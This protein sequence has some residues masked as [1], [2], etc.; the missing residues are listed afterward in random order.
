MGNSSG[1][2]F[3][4]RRTRTMP[5]NAYSDYPDDAK[6]VTMRNTREYR[7][8]SGNA[9]PKPWNLER[10]MEK[11]PEMEVYRGQQCPM[12]FHQLKEAV[13]PVW[14]SGTERSR[15]SIRATLLRSRRTFRS[16]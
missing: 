8:V 1:S 7:K 3:S 13:V 16:T 15:R 10:Y 9:A 2:K 11:H 12:D 5:P 14:R 6:R 4:K